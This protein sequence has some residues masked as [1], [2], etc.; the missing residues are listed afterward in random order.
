MKNEY[1]EAT[2]TTEKIHD[3]AATDNKPRIRITAP[4]L[5]LRSDIPPHPTLAIASPDPPAILAV[6]DECAKYS[7][8]DE[9]ECVR[10]GGEISFEEVGVGVVDEPPPQQNLNV[11]ARS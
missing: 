6:D 1:D 7:S 8:N 3:K 10:R 9:L 4:L 11:S 5:D 2:D